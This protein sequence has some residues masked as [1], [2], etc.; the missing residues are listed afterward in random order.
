MAV[1]YIVC[2]DSSLDTF[3]SKIHPLFQVFMHT[4]YK[5]IYSNFHHKGVAATLTNIPI[6]LDRLLQ[7]LRY[8]DFQNMSDIFEIIGF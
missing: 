6:L 8:L 7:L 3:N 2:Q 5:V 1:S 4:D